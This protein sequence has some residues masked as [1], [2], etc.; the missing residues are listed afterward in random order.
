MLSAG[1]PNRGII[2]IVATLA[3][4]FEVSR[5][6][7][8]GIVVKMHDGQDDLDYFQGNFAVPKIGIG[9][10]TMQLNKLAT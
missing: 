8:F 4:G 3:G 6:A 9:F 1:S 7:V 10:I 5:I 2:T